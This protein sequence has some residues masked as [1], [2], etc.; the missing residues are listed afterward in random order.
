MKKT[1]GKS[2]KREQKKARQITHRVT[3]HRPNGAESREVAPEKVPVGEAMRRAVEELGEVQIDKELAPEQLRQLADSYDEVA[4][5]KA[6]FSVK[7]ED[8][9][10]AKKSL[11][12]ATEL[13]L[14]MVKEF[15]HPTPLPLF[16]S[17]QE[18]GDRQAMIDATR[19]EAEF[20]TDADGHVTA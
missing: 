7:A 6:A 19:V 5:A 3:T 20:E 13:L 18:E 12:C 9:K 11:D 17:A 4:R 16:D 14:D 2:A 8:A 10:I 15:T 1:P